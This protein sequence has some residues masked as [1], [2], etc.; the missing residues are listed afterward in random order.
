MAQGRV[1]DFANALQQMVTLAMAVRRRM[2]M[3]RDT[4]VQ[5]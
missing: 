2:N 5:G 3:K 4:G 1:D